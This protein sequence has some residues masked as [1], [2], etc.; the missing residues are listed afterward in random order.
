MKTFE[1]RARENRGAAKTWINATNRRCASKMLL[2]ALFLFP[3]SLLAQSVQDGPWPLTLQ[4]AVN[5]ALEKNPLHKAALADE[6]ATRANVIETR[7]ALFPRVEFSEGFTRSNDPVFVFGSKLRQERF[8]NADF[9]PSVLNTPGPV[10]NFGTRIETKWN[11]FDSGASWFRLSAARQLEQAS[12][13]RLTRADQE[14]IYAAVGAY[15]GLL[16]ATKQQKVAELAVQTAQ[17]IHGDAKNRVEAGM[18]VESDLLSAEVLLDQRQQ[19]LV[20]AK[21]D[22]ALAQAQLSN[23][24]GLPFDQPFE[25][26]DALPEHSPPAPSLPELESKALQARADLSAIHLEQN[27]QAKKVWAAKAAFAP[28]I[29]LFGAWEQDNQYF[30]SNGG[31]NYTAG[32]E[33]QIDLFTGGARRAEFL[34]QQANAE[35]LSAL[36][37]AAQ[38]EIRL[39]LRR[40]YYEFDSDRQRL[41]LARNALQQGEE[42]LRINQNRYDS[43][44]T[45]ITDLLR[46]EESAQRSRAEYWQAVYRMR[47]DYAALEL[48]A[49][50]L[51]PTSSAVMP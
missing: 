36:Q 18:V 44:L 14:L 39:E 28:R 30:T 6:H 24:L 15:Y 40:A 37:R 51:T 2:A 27:A 3:T 35:K 32:A 22:V 26:A 1:Q 31:S 12:T 45:T 48:A 10:N 16:L 50:T 23:A 42:S 5:I 46:A 25:P 49:G 19:E 21:N 4:Q 29:N 33:L 13:Q 7:A 41:D 9:A 47:T 20:R 43:G 38:S 34:L 17:S 11:I 8:S